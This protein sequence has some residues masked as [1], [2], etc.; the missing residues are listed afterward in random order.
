MH[1]SGIY[2][3][4]DMKNGKQY[5]GQTDDLPRRRDQHLHSLQKGKHPNKQMQRDF[6][7]YKTFLR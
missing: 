5:V 7:K 1:V 3:I 2:V 4:T 6:K